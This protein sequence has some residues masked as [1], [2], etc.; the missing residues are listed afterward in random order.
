MQDHPLAAG[1]YEQL[2]KLFEG[3]KSYDEA[4]KSFF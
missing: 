1:V 3:M 4:Y 2:G